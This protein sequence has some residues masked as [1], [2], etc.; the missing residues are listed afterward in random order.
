MPPVGAAPDIQPAPQARQ[1]LPSEN[2]MASELAATDWHNAN[3]KPLEQHVPETG[4]NLGAIQE[5]ELPT[6]VMPPAPGAIKVPVAPVAPTPVDATAAFTPQPIGAVETPPAPAVA[7]SPVPPTYPTPDWEAMAG[8]T[9]AGAEPSSPGAESPSASAYEELSPNKLDA[10]TATGTEAQA[11]YEYMSNDPEAMLAVLQGAL[12][13][14]DAEKRSDKLRAIGP[15]IKNW[16]D[17]NV[18]PR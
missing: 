8:S 9:K 5:E 18:T 3:Q 11:F 2:S 15:M 12:R 14:D 16:I 13:E 10:E 6:D 17:R 1:P 4:A 7:P